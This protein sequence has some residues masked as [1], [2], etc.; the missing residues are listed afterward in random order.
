MHTVKYYILYWGTFWFY[1]S[2]LFVWVGV[3]QHCKSW[4]E[5]ICPLFSAKVLQHCQLART[6]PVHCAQPLQIALLMFTLIQAGP[7]QNFNLFLEEQYFCWFGGMLW[8]GVERWQKF[9]VNLSL[10][11]TFHQS[12]HTNSLEA[13]S[14]QD[15]TYMN[16]SGNPARIT[17]LA[18]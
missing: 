2:T 18:R 9:L 6:S 5:N 7:L 3:C 15:A 17:E 10:I 11:N 16:M 13:R 1:S 4:L 14:L 8:V 12:D